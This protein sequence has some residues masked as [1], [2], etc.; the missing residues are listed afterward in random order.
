MV[1]GQLI[2]VPEQ[3]CNREVE[4]TCN[5]LQGP[6]AHFLVALLQVRHI[7]FVD[8]CLLGKINLTPAA[9]LPQLPNSLSERNANVPC[10]PYYGGSMMGA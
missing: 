1:A 2:D 9:L 4:R 6:Q 5:R 10:H 3:I 7:V 8:S